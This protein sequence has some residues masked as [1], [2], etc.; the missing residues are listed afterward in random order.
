MRPPRPNSTGRGNPLRY[1]DIQNTAVNVNCVASGIANSRDRT[2]RMNVYRSDGGGRKVRAKCALFEVR[3]PSIVHTK[4]CKINF[5]ELNCNR[6]NAF[7][8][9]CSEHE[10]AIFSAWIF[11][12]R[13]HIRRPQDY[14]GWGT[15]EVCV[16]QWEAHILE[17]FTI[18]S[19][20]SFSSCWQ[21]QQQKQ[22]QRRLYL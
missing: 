3:W 7:R 9:M 21:Q 15:A 13:R 14:G 19:S 4:K 17:A 6:C 20:S 5:N 2:M 1:N 22:R 16:L 8:I 11:P 12:L 10:C 18:S